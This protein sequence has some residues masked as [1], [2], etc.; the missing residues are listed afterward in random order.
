MQLLILCMSIRVAIREAYLQIKRNPF[1]SCDMGSFVK[2]N[3][4][5]RNPKWAIQEKAQA[6]H[7]E[8]L[9]PQVK[10]SK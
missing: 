3:E 7:A 4:P 10:L 9:N 1:L 8:L 2:C 5:Y 6:K